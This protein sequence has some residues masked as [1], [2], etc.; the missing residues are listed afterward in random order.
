MTAGV[1]LP[2]WLL[3][4]PTGRTSERPALRG[5]PSDPVV[6]LMLTVAGLG[7]VPGPP[8]VAPL[9]S[10]FPS[11]WGAPVPFRAEQQ[12][13]HFQCVCRESQSNAWLPRPRQGRLC[14]IRPGAG[15]ASAPKP[16]VAPPC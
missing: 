5:L 9:R 10:S 6:A 12:Q 3:R 8:D 1:P 13:L 15:E 14:E 11:F 16:R 7:R 2:P 4:A